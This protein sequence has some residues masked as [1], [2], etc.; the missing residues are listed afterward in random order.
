MNSTFNL[1]LF[2]ILYKWKREEKCKLELNNT[3]TN[4]LL[5]S[6]NN[7]LNLMEMTK[8]MVSIILSLRYIERIDVNTKKV[9]TKKM[10]SIIFVSNGYIEE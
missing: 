5:Y 8:I 6:M 10:P 2:S 3:I 9:N 1:F 7:A 4:V